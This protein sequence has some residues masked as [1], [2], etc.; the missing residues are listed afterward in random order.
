MEYFGIERR[1]FHE[2]LRQRPAL[3]IGLLV[4]LVHSQAQLAEHAL[5]Q[6]IAIPIV[7]KAPR[8]LACVKDVP[9]GDSPLTKDLALEVGMMDDFYD[10]L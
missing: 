8:Y 2:G 1:I 7:P 6:R 3:P 4:G 10:A 9:D 5:V